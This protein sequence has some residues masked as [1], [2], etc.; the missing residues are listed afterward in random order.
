MPLCQAHLPT[1]IPAPKDYFECIKYSGSGGLRSFT[2][3]RSGKEW[4]PDLI[5]IKNL[6]NNHDHVLTDT[7]RGNDKVIRSNLTNGEFTE[8]H[9]IQ[10]FNSDGFSVEGNIRFNASSNDYV[11]WCWSWWKTNC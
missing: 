1:P 8:S 3:G 10:Q 7:C 2:L 5:W 9:G 6:T 4:Q 11:A